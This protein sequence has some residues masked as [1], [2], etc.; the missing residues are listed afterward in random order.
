MKIVKCE[1]SI[2]TL[3]GLT[4][5]LEVNPRLFDDEVRVI[6]SGRAFTVE[7]G[8]ITESA[9][10][11]GGSVQRLFAAPSTRDLQNLIN[12]FKPATLTHSGGAD[13]A[14]ANEVTEPKK[15]TTALPGSSDSI[16]QH[17]P[18]QRRAWNYNSM[19]LV[20]RREDSR[21]RR[22][23]ACVKTT[24][25]DLR[26]PAPEQTV[27]RALSGLKYASTPKECRGI[28]EE[29]ICSIEELSCFVT[30]EDA[31]FAK[32]QEPL[33]RHISTLVAQTHVKKML[34]EGLEEANTRTITKCLAQ[35]RDF[36]R[37]SSDNPLFSDVACFIKP[38]LNLEK[39]NG[40]C[41]LICRIRGC[42]A[43]ALRVE[44]QEIKDSGTE[45]LFKLART[46]TGS[47]LRETRRLAAEKV[48]THLDQVYPGKSGH[49]HCLD[50]II[51]DT[52]RKIE[53]ML[54]AKLYLKDRDLLWKEMAKLRAGACVSDI[55]GKLS[56]RELEDRMQ[57]LHQ[58][59]FT[60]TP[61]SSEQVV[62]MLLD[63]QS[64]EGDIELLNYLTVGTRI[65]DDVIH[66]T[67]QRMLQAAFLKQFTIQLE[68]ELQKR[69]PEQGVATIPL[70]QSLKT[71][72]RQ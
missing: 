22:S 38:S 42:P 58:R 71:M 48:F 11:W 66:K 45:A 6:V 33:L 10:R 17:T 40:L 35:H 29:S 59:C 8:Q 1:I 36:T 62:A 16:P 56:W 4:R 53:D 37:V 14:A 3:A 65:A 19:G 67:S 39:T 34:N 46:Q 49:L 31:L 41:E 55:T 32:I 43:K 50:Q 60:E 28:L 63:G 12:R 51:T 2:G 5:L 27:R 26:K 64:L 52:N 61:V 47:A 54:V 68:R 18:R 44:F 23:L 21:N 72:V 13:G 25:P 7:N 30:V 57:T 9:R 24:E 15:P 20:A 70:L 69:F